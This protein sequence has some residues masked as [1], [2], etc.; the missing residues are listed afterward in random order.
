MA[1]IYRRIERPSGSAGSQESNDIRIGTL[2]QPA[3]LWQ[4]SRVF[5]A[6]VRFDDAAP[7]LR[8]ILWRADLYV[9]TEVLRERTPKVGKLH[10]SILEEG[11]Y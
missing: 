5:S 6:P 11:G 8:L 3:K 9:L 7:S 2:Q 4:Q 10:N 1:G